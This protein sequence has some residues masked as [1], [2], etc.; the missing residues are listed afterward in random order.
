MSPFRR[1][2]RAA[3][4]F[5]LIVCGAIGAGVL[6]APSQ[7][8]NASGRN[9]IARNGSVQGRLYPGDPVR[10]AELV[11]SEDD[12]LAFVRSIGAAIAGEEDAMGG[13]YRLDTQPAST[14]VLPAAD[15]P[16]TL[17]TLQDLAPKT[18]VQQ[19]DGAYLLSENIVVLPGAA[20]DLSG[21]TRTT[22][23]LKSDGASFVSVISFGGALKVTGTEQA[24][25]TIE[26]RDPLTGTADENTIDGRA[27]VRVVGGTAEISHARFNELGFWS[28]N[29]GGLALTGL[30]QPAARPAIDS[31]PTSQNEPE[32]QGEGEENG[33]PTLSTEE[34][35][36]LAA[37]DQ[38]DPGLV[39]GT[40]Q[41]VSTSGNAFG[42]FVS[43][44]TGVTISEASIRD[45]LVDGVV[46]HRFVTDSEIRT[47]ESTGNA[48]DGL[49]IVQSSSAIRVSGFTASGNGRNGISIDGRPLADGPSAIG[50]PVSSYGDITVS[51]G[52]VADNARYG[53][54]VSGGD[55]VTIDGARISGNAVGVMLNHG[56]KHVDVIGSTFYKQE[57]QSI[58]LRGGVAD[59]RLLDNAVSSVD[60][61]I[62]LRD[63]SAEVAGNTFAD[64]SNHAIT[65]IGA[66]S[67]ARVTGN[68]ISGHGSAP[69]HDDA[70]GAMVIGNDVDGWE[71]PPTA[72]SV[73]HTIF[74]P[75]TV[76][77]VLLGLLLVFTALTGHRRRGIRHP[78]A[79]QVP[80]TQLS[81]GVV[82]PDSLRG[83]R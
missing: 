6:F 66:A 21:E 37:D 63:A 34:L 51:G 46:F 54:E 39:S 64:V 68:T 69:I 50:T 17:A 23:L 43:R 36:A 75:L 77:W 7:G 28:G 49:S 59:S 73:M 16:Y 30:E 31:A 79:E 26:S 27:Y 78:Y 29:T 44:A 81:R 62:H 76:I 56:A 67:G 58:A 65:L 72:G 9:E 18:F 24:P 70:S 4:V 14:L 83:T 10:E 48:V 15:E 32:S 20:L 19:P 3:A 60:T 5:V 61:G 13:P 25:V 11:A 80:L 22:I 52:S 41:D 55:G 71:V 57:R 8:L 82:P 2:L 40:L 47:T 1:F 38:P 35:E 53:I 74:Q 45:S 12:R 42:L 33:A